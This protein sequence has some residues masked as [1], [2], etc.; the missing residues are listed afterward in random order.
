MMPTRKPAIPPLAYRK[1]RNVNLSLGNGDPQPPPFS[2]KPGVVFVRAG[3]RVSRRQ[4]SYDSSTA[5]AC[6]ITSE[7]DE[8]QALIRYI[9]SENRWALPFACADS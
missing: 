4:E 6:S 2:S 7:T 1:S 9:P 8:R 3:V 5:F